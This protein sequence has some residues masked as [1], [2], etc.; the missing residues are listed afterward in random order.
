ML[1]KAVRCF[2]SCDRQRF[3]LRTRATAVPGCLETARADQSELRVGGGEEH[4][5]DVPAAALRL[6]RR[7]VDGHIHLLAHNLHE[8]RVTLR[9]FDAGRKVPCSKRRGNVQ[10]AQDYRA[11][12]AAASDPVQLPSW[13]ALPNPSYKLQQCG[14]LLGFCTQ[15]RSTPPLR[16][17]RHCANSDAINGTT[18]YQEHPEIRAT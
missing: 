16:V 8:P 9:R 15:R 7:G 6:L 18:N 12:N 2:W 5:R 13:S 1:R 10:R 14:N 11:S 3:Q 4:L 17:K